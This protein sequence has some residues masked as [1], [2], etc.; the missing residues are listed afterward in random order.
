MRVF[1]MMVA[2]PVG[3]MMTEILSWRTVRL[4]SGFGSVVVMVAV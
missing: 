2:V 3:P 4:S 1:K